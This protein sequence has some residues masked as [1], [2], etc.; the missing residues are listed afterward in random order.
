MVLLSDRN[1]ERTRRAVL[2]GR[3]IP[4]MASVIALIALA[5]ALTVRVFARG[6]F[7][8]IG[9][10]LWWAAQTV[11]TV[12]YGDVIPQTPFSTVVAVIVMFMGVATVSI[13]TAIITSAL[14]TASQQRIA[15]LQGDPELG[16]IL[17]IEQRLEALQRIEQRLDVIEHRVGPR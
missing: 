16:A 1:L 7:D 4:Y 3:I 11:T 10:S 14:I 5:A 2:S 17:R 6:E 13:A 9:E 12:G 15:E 8:S